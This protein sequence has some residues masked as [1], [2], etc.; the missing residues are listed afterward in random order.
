[1]GE[2]IAF[3]D[4]QAENYTCPRCG[5]PFT[6]QTYGPAQVSVNDSA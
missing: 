2:V 6:G 5:L 3:P 1:M 4:R